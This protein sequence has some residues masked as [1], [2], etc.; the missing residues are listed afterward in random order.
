MGAVSNG[1]GHGNGNSRGE[2]V[3]ERL[4]LR[5]DALP[6]TTSPSAEGV[7]LRSSTGDVSRVQGACVDCG[8]Q[9]SYEE[10]CVKCHSCGFTECG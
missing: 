10:G 7:G 2:L 5:G 6:P 4:A 9:L 1:N 8:G 3:A